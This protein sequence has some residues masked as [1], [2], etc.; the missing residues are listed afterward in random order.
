MNTI[1]PDLHEAL[2]ASP[3]AKGLFAKA[4]VESGGG[5]NM[6]TTLAQKESEGADFATKAGF[7]DATLAQLR[8]MRHPTVLH[9]F[10]KCKV[11]VSTLLVGVNLSIWNM[12]NSTAIISFP[13]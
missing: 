8:S 11:S 2:R 4:I 9:P 6:P 5:W 1:D 3:L 7:A 10:I 13:Y 12:Q